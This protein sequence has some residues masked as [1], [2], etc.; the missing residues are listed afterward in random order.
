MINEL[1]YEQLNVKH[2]LGALALAGL[3]GAGGVYAKKAHDRRNSFRGKM[4]RFGSDVR[5]KAEKFGRDAKKIAKQG[6]RHLKDNLDSGIEMGK[7]YGSKAGQF[8]KDHKTGI[9][10]TGAGLAAGGLAYHHRDKLADAGKNLGNWFR[11]R[12]AKE[13]SKNVNLPATR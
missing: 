6:S 1:V 13:N 2:V 11:N 9:A 5:D 8:V 10:L 12:F 4:E 3:A 7:K